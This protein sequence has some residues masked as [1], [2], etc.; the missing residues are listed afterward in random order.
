MHK[1]LANT[2]LTDEILNVYPLKFESRKYVH[3]STHIEDHRQCR[4]SK[5]IKR[6]KYWKEVKL[7]LFAVDKFCSQT[8]Q[9]NL[10]TVGNNEWIQQ[11]C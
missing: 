10:R 9:N 11:S 4:T 5:K 1:I 8:F 3:Y 6:Y 2:T 7:V